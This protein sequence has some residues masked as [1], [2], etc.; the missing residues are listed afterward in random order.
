MKRYEDED[1]TVVWQGLAQRRAVSYR[2]QKPPAADGVQSGMDAKI[3]WDWANDVLYR[4]CRDYPLH[5]DHEVIMGKIWLIG[6]AYAAPIE[7]GAGTGGDVYPTIA[8]KIAGSGLDKWLTSVSDVKSVAMENLHR[9]LAAH[10]RLT[11]LLKRHTQRE[12]RSFASKYLHFH[13]PS[14][15]FIFDSRADREIRQRMGRG[16]F[17]LPPS[18]VRAD[19]AYAA[20]VLRCI[21]YRDQD[22]AT[23]GGMPLT[24]RQLDKQL[25]GYR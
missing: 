18:C 4:M 3:S 23:F 19:P 11:A 2:M 20:F 12:R 6:R 13:N 5:E 17:L 9:V 14:A 24:P 8:S 22:A 16:H 1:R 21:K 7:R 15:F 25:L 10:Q